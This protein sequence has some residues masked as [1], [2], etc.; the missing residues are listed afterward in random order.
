MWSL[1]RNVLFALFLIWAS[2]LQAQQTS[3]HAIGTTIDILGGITNNPNGALGLNT[4]GKGFTPLYGIFPALNVTTTGRSSFN[5]SYAYGLNRTSGGNQSNSES[6]QAHLNYSRLLSPKTK[7]TFLEAFERTSDAA[8]FNGLRGVAPVVQDFNFVFYPV[9][10]KQVALTAGSAVTM[11]YALNEKSSISTTGSVNIRNYGQVSTPL[12][13]ALVNQDGATGSFAYRRRMTQHD[14]WSVLYTGSYFRFKGFD[15]TGSHSASFEYL[16]QI[17]TNVRF[18]M[19]VGISD[20]RNLRIGTSYVGYNTTLAL[21]RV[22]KKTNSI[23]VNYSQQS[24][25]PTGLS[26]ISDS[27]QIGLS[28]NHTARHF[29][30]FADLSAYDSQGRLGNDLNGRG[31]SA[32]GNVGLILSKKV[33]LQVGGQFQR[34]KQIAPLE[35]TQKRLFLSLRFTDPTLLHW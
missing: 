17:S 16:D 32:A 11:D 23:S 26:T 3:T 12:R 9:A 14:T 1:F 30:I 19:S 35:F 2:R 10:V 18:Q 8:T 21:Q 24:G 29:S 13:G 15:N 28:A 7:I 33:S 5:L 22:L 27:R 31:V 25:Q 6:H 4:S 34:S 20:T